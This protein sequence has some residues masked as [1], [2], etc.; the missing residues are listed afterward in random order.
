MVKN[1]FNIQYG[2]QQNE[3]CR[4]YEGYVVLCSLTRREDKTLKQTNRKGD[5]LRHTYP[6]PK[7]RYGSRRRQLHSSP[8]SLL[9][10]MLCSLL[11]CF[12][13]LC[14][15]ASRISRGV[16][17]CGSLRR[18]WLRSSSL[19]SLQASFDGWGLPPRTPPAAVHTDDC[20]FSLSWLDFIDLR[21][22]SVSDKPS[23]LQHGN[24]EAA[25]TTFHHPQLRRS[26]NF[27]QN[28]SS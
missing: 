13:F 17:F 9:L 1:V 28:P 3:S 19:L 20:S 16:W 26:D 27:H 12:S 6:S 18:G 15:F 21:L 24:V 14:Y 25:K 8:A 22:N 23:W 5:A 11:S 10:A 7:I 4:M 2:N